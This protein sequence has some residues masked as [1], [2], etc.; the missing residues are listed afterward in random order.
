MSIEV[1][2]DIIP[3]MVITRMLPLRSLERDENKVT[4]AETN[5]QTKKLANNELIDIFLDQFRE[6]GYFI[7]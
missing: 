6:R 5:K 4:S 2:V 3:T 1:V 7:V